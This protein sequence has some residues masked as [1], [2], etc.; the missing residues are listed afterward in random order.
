M[1]RISSSSTSLWVEKPFS[2]LFLC[3]ICSE[4]NIW[5]CE[6]MCVCVLVC[7]YL[8]VWFLFLYFFYFVPII[9][10]LRP[11]SCYCMP[12]FNYGGIA[13][14]QC[15]QALLVDVI[16]A[17]ICL[18]ISSITACFK[19]QLGNLFVCFILVLFLCFVCFQL[20][21]DFQHVKLCRY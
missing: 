11:A 17:V 12:S 16:S 5:R 18:I 10:I 9:T 13:R 2:P 6:S 4:I 21:L 14:R 8:C 7:V 1:N 15:N 20:T 3:S 19:G